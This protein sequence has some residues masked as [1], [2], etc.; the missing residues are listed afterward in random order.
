MANTLYWHDYETFGV[1]PRWDRPA[2]FA[3]IRTDE[4]LN[5]IG[6]PMELFCKPV[7]DILP[8]PVSC[9]ITGI[10]PQIAEAKGI[11]EPEFIAR[12]NAEFSVPGTC[13]VGYN[14]LRFDDE[15]TRHTL[16]RNFYDP[17]VREWR[18]GNS[19]WDII[20]LSRMTYALRPAGIEWPRH[21]DGRV[22]F[23][24]EQLAAA[25]GLGH[26][27][28]H[29]A[30][31]DV[32]AT[33]EWARLLK[34]KQPRLFGWLYKLRDKRQADDQLDLIQRTLVLHSSGMYP[35]ETG[36]TST[37]EVLPP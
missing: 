7:R 37:Q 36:C 13:G 29:D 35:P 20:D 14:S 28:A 19:R 8:D 6:E 4:D 30:L 22:S 16:Y 9:L 33:I 3:G 25:N 26:E 24:L 27:S 23:K 10:T 17:Y 21:E 12:I 32:R 1:N 5:E 15:V 34:E 31:S 18:D 11:F 2:Q